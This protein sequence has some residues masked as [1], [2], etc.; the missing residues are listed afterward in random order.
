MMELVIKN[1]T[2]VDEQ[3]GFQ[4]S[5]GISRGKIAAIHSSG[6]GLDAEQV[7]DATGRLVLPGVLDVHVHMEL[8]VTGMVSSDDF[9]SG[10]VAAACGGV[11]TIIDFAT[12]AKGESLLKAVE[13]RRALAEPKTAVDFS[14][15]CAITDWTDRTKREMGKVVRA[16]VTSFKLFMAYKDRGWM[17]DDG[18]LYECFGEAARHDAVVGVH[19]ENPFIIDRFTA[20]ALASG[21]RGA[22]L[23]GLSRPNFSES[24]AVQRAI[25]LASLSDARVYIFHMT[26]QEACAIVEE[27]QLQGYPVAAETCPQF[28][29]LSNQLFRRKNGHLFATCPPLR[30]EDDALYLWEALD[31]GSIQVVATDH[32]TFTRKQ[33]AKWRGD[34]RKIPCGLPGVETLL[35][36]MFTYG[37]DAGRISLE[38]LVQVLSANPARIFGLYPRKGAIKVGS[39]AD[40]VVI[41]P[42]REVRVSPKVLHMNC[43]FSPYQGFMLKGFPSLTLLRGKVIQRDGNFIGTKGDGLFLRRA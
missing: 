12:Q 38:T 29:V 32:C 28:L 20:A 11:T 25:Y 8:P 42:E 1:G 7:I 9:A 43:D 18:M 30:T 14:L 6:V 15:H 17:A 26:T 31:C 33:K 21:K 24:E 16:G 35:P 39:D 37:Y 22:R 41:D 2:L 36:I 10:T 27:W 3:G 13:A 5:I 23:H 40:L 4:G 34:F 19:A